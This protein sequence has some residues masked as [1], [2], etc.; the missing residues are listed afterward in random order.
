MQQQLWS[1]GKLSA[2]RIY[3]LQPKR[4]EHVA[5]V[6]SK[7]TKRWDERLGRDGV[8]YSDTKVAFDT[9]RDGGRRIPEGGRASKKRMGRQ[10]GSGQRCES[11]NT[12]VYRYPILATWARR[13]AASR[14]CIASRRAKSTVE[15][16]LR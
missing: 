3:L 9:Q 7:G 13:Q 1:C 6:S 11:V 5:D 2:G 15:H 8:R 4:R 10:W 14:A 16:A 12:P